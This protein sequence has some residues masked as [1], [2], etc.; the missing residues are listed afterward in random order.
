MQCQITVFSRFGLSES[1]MVCFVDLSAFFNPFEP[2][3][4]LANLLDPFIDS[5]FL[6]VYKTSFHTA[7]IVN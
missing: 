1:K 3:Y 5:D 2:H 6:L 4:L 7:R